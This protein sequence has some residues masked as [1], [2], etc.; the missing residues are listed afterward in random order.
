MLSI[1]S[2]RLMEKTSNPWNF[3]YLN[4]I[5]LRILPGLCQIIVDHAA[6]V[7]LRFRHRSI[8]TF[9]VPA[10]LVFGVQAFEHEFARGNELCDVG[11]PKSK[12]NQRGF[13]QLRNRIEQVQTF[14]RGS[15]VGEQ[16]FVTFV[17]PLDRAREIDTD[18]IAFEN[19][20][21]SAFDEVA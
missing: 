21:R 16:Q 11:A 18:K 5:K 9:L 10:N 1:N 15:R 2:P 13:D 7:F 6:T 3:E 12:R 8:T 4:R 14:A 17:K 19:L 20:T